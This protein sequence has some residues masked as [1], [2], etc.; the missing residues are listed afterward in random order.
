MLEI[1]PIFFLSSHMDIMPISYVIVSFVLLVIV[2]SEG[3]YAIAGTASA[4]NPPK[5][6]SVAIIDASLVFIAVGA[7]LCNIRSAGKD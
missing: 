6:A 5:T 2:M 3:G 7:N 4:N 1:M